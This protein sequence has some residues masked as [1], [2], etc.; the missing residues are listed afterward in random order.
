MFSK[1]A[2]LN[3]LVDGMLGSLAIK[4]RILGL[5]TIYDKISD[6]NTLLNTARVT[7]RCLVTS[8]TD[9]FLQCRRERVSSV[10]IS[11]RDDLNRLV[12]LY[13]KLGLTRIS[14]PKSSRCS[15][16]NGSLRGPEFQTLQLK[17]IYTCVVCRKKYWKGSHWKKIE[18]LFNEANLKLAEFERSGYGN[19][20]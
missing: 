1:N 18:A 20:V 7:H 6:D 16:C 14:L 4:M 17:D 12:E 8:D 2:E 19:K 5:D 11:S 10:L 9:L 3:F 15:A 13:C